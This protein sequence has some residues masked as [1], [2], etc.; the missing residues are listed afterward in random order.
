MLESI[1]PWAYLW[2]A[3]FLVLFVVIVLSL[4][5][6]LVLGVLLLGLYYA[7]PEKLLDQAI[8]WLVSSSREKF[9]HYFQKV[10]DHLRL[11]FPIH[12]VTPNNLP[13]TCLLL[14]HPHSLLSITA[15]LHTCFKISELESKIVNHSFYHSIP[16]V[17]DIARYANTVPARF[18]EMQKT[19]EEGNRLSVVIGG[20]REMMELE[21]KTIKIFSKRKGIFRLALLNGTPIVPILSYG[22]SEMFPQIKDPYLDGLNQFLYETFKIAIPHT[23][24]KA[25]KNWLRL[26]YEPLDTIPTYIG[27]PISVEKISIPTEKDI[28]QLRKKYIESVKKLFKET[29]PA[30][31]KLVIV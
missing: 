3:V 15:V 1:L 11:T 31:Y 21:E 17:R 30:D 5:L 20:V 7:L 12:G 24:V 4:A 6:N 10:E 26:Y 18:D 23:T 16:I 14:W 19:L 13:K 22:E 27:E 2:P 29:H 28:D 8:H 25:L 9:E